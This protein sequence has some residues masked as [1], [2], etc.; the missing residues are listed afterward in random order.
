MEIGGWKQISL[1]E[2]QR[3]GFNATPTRVMPGVARSVFHGAR[4]GMVS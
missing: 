1:A 3:R 2:R 4:E